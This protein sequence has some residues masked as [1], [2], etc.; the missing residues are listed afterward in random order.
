LQL[1]PHVVAHV[2]PD[3][4]ATVHSAPHATVQ[5]V[6][7]SHV[8]LQPLP[9]VE[10]CTSQ[11]APPLHP[12]EEPLHAHD[13]PVHVGMLAELPLHARTPAVI[14]KATPNARRKMDPF[15][16]LQCALGAIRLPK[17]HGSQ[18]ALEQRFWTQTP[19]QQ[20]DAPL[21]G[22]P[23]MK[24][25]DA[26]TEMPCAFGVHAPA[27]QS[28]SAVQG[29][30]GGLHWPGPTSHRFDAGSHTFEQQSPFCVHRS[31]VRRHVVSS[32]MQLPLSQ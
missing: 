12:H 6:T 16:T 23:S 29:K 10:H 8:A 21:H 13:A 19:L 31:A 28:L 14:T 2:S 22:A 9:P 32:A 17:L 20:S 18:L 4:H 11:L 7:P 15:M 5:F 30:S 26:H 27:Q 1:A 25:L 3:L 24:Q